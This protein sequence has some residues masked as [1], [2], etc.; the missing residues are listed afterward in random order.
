MHKFLTIV[1]P[2]YNREK[3]LIRLLRSLERQDAVDRY[4]IVVLDNHSNYDVRGAL[5]RFFSGEFLENIEV[6]VRPYNS[7]GDYNIS[8]A[9]LFAKSDY[10]WIIGDDDEVLDGCIG[11]IEEDVRH[12]PDIP[13]FKYHNEGHSSFQNDLVINNI[14]EFQEA[15]EQRCFCAGDI[16]FVSNNVY[17]LKAAASYIPSSLYYSYCSIP[18]ALPT[19]RCLQD[20]KPFVWSHRELVRYHSPEGDHWNYVKIATSLSTV[21]DIHYGSDYAV[22]KTFFKILSRHFDPLEF[23]EECMKVKDKKYASYVCRKGLSAL[24]DGRFFYSRYCHFLYSI[25]RTA[26]IKVLSLHRIIVDSIKRKRR[27]MIDGN[28]PLYRVYKILFKR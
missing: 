27:R 9:F 2:T 20:E 25:E 24:F 13:F 26:K 8:S 6:Y 28:G 10:L 19:L 15:Y 14:K 1:I 5:S 22:T 3:Q 12:Y 16:I 23:M 21:L 17:N 18:H 11:T 7:G 4:T